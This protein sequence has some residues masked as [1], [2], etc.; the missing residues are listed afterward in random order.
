MEFRIIENIKTGKKYIELKRNTLN[1]KFDNFN[2]LNS[3]LIK[4]NLSKDYTI[5]NKN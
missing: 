1:N 4:L 3:M 5:V 2:Q